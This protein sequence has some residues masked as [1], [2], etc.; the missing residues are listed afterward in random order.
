MTRI[1]AEMKANLAMRR[2][3]LKKF[4]APEEHAASQERDA[5]QNS[6]ASQADKE[7]EKRRMKTLAASVTGRAAG[8]NKRTEEKPKKKYEEVRQEKRSTRVHTHPKAGA[9]VF[10]YSTTATVK[11]KESREEELR[12][13]Q[14][15]QMEDMRQKAE[16]S[17]L[18]RPRSKAERRWDTFMRLWF[19]VDLAACA[20]FGFMG[21]H[22]YAED[23]KMD[24]LAWRLSFGLVI[25]V[26]LFKN[27]QVFAGLIGWLSIWLSVTLPVVVGHSYG[28]AVYFFKIWGGDWPCFRGEQSNYEYQFGVC[29]FG[30]L[31][32][33][34]TAGACF[35]TINCLLLWRW[36]TFTRASRLEHGDIEDEISLE[37]MLKS[38]DQRMQQA[39]A[40]AEE[41]TQALKDDLESA[42]SEATDTMTQQERDH[43]VNMAVR[44]G[45]I[46]GAPRRKAAGGG[47]LT[48]TTSAQ[49][50]PAFAQNLSEYQEMDIDREV[51]LEREAK[52]GKAPPKGGIGGF[53][54]SVRRS[55]TVNPGFTPAQVQRVRGPG[56]N[57]ASSSAANSRANTP[58][59]SG[60]GSGSGSG[61]AAAAEPPR[62]FQSTS[63]PS[64]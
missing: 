57:T 50:H 30:T 42:V 47:A 45:K 18:R 15:E 51:R 16:R 37:D 40:A 64:S 48:S 41:V 8:F 26:T 4:K 55:Q 49:D 24:P 62:L 20:F 61:S 27:L 33:A 58:S 1:K 46:A 43:V 59:V 23:L 2:E 53:M 11:T 14:R 9:T 52:E 54:P 10:N 25:V 44:T 31:L 5:L 60:S 35:M 32:G 39:A 34:F 17:L 6:L 7:E 19:L 38:V 21:F 13:A 56:S 3:A 63:R 36:V 22:L 28:A 12:A 29:K